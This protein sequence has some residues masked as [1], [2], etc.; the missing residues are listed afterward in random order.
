MSETKVPFETVLDSVHA[1]GY[2]DI[3]S[4][5]GYPD[6]AS[7]QVRLPEQHRRDPPTGLRRFLSRVYCNAGDPDLVPND[8]RTAV[9]RHGW[10]VQAMGRD[11]QQMTVIISPNG[12]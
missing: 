1:L 2:D 4:T 9:E 8:L 3:T 11:D 12:V 6:E 5:D 10:T 7:G